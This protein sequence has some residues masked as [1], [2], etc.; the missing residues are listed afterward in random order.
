MHIV[1]YFDHKGKFNLKSFFFPFLYYNN[2]LVIQYLNLRMPHFVKILYFLQSFFQSFFGLG[3]GAEHRHCARWRRNEETSRDQDRWWSE[4]ETLSVLWW[5]E[6]HWKGMKSVTFYNLLGPVASNGPNGHSNFYS[7]VRGTLRDTNRII[8]IIII[9]SLYVALITQ[10]GST[11]Q[12]IPCVS[13]K[14][15]HLFEVFLNSYFM[16]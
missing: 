8:I 7:T 16:I 5:R 6:P 15:R 13:K 10:I 4:G 3:Q 2:C 9:C 11:A 14:T 1:L 12:Y